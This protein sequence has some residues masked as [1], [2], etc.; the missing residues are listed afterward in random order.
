VYAQG[1]LTG[2]AEV[3]TADHACAV[4]DDS[5]AYTEAARQYLAERLA[6]GDRLVPDAQPAFCQQATSRAPADGYRGLRVVAELTPLATAA[7]P[8]GD[9]L[10]WEHRADDFMAAGSEVTA[11][12]FADA[13]G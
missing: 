4:Y 3:R 2:P 11:V 10:R 12:S 9:L 13:P 1:V 5:A 6:R 7:G 8:S